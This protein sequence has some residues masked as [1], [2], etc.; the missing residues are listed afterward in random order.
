MEKG[1]AY[2]SKF[3][4]QNTDEVS[5]GPFSEKFPIILLSKKYCSFSEKFELHEQGE[6]AFATLSNSEGRSQ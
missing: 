6:K 4:I 3:F 1:D 5:Q 2:F